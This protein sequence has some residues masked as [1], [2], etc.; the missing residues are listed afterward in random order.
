ME[1]K[2][3]IDIEILRGLNVLIVEDEV[4]VCD[5]LAKRI[6]KFFNNV[7][8][9]YDGIEGLEIFRAEKI[10]LIMTDLNM[11]KMDGLKMIEH[12]REEDGDV[13]IILITAQNDSANLIAAINLNI[14]QFIEKPVKLRKLYDSMGSA[15]QNEVI[16]NLQK[17]TREQ[18]IE[19]MKHREKYTAE[20]MNRAFLKELSLLKNDL[21]TKMWASKSDNDTFY[22]FTTYYIP[23]EVL[24]GD[25]FSLRKITDYKHF[26]F[27]IDTMGKGVSA[28]V[29]TMLSVAFINHACDMALNNDDFNFFD[30]VDK[31]IK[32][33][34][35]VLLDDE[36]VSAAFFKV[37][38]EN[39][40]LKYSCFGM[41]AMLVHNDQGDIDK[42]KSNN[43]PISKYTKEFELDNIH[44]T[45][46]EKILIYSDGLIE[47]ETNEGQMYFD[48]IEED[49]R[50]SSFSR[51]FIKKV[52]E[53]IK[54]F[55]DDV[56]IIG[57]KKI[58]YKPDLEFSFEI[59]TRR[60]IVEQNIENFSNE[61]KSKISDEHIVARA[62]TVYHEMLMNAY[63]HGNLNLSYESK[64][65]LIEMD[66][67][68][69]H[70]IEAEKN[71]TKKIK[72]NY[73]LYT[74]SGAKFLAVKVEDEGTGFNMNITDRALSN[75]SYYNGRGILMSKTFADE[76]YYNENGNIVTF[77]MQV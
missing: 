52:K 18:E 27:I 77:F 73:G 74:Q 59:D 29:T 51:V 26:G 4:Q 65:I 12:I 2:I 10:D 75:L 28:S 35:K 44:M 14:T 56:T 43:P 60:D 76:M 50:D 49:F 16:R 71:C 72:I 31:Y 22:G 70:L 8:K 19:L 17:Q 25:C 13:P 61:L 40:D 58:K 33:I 62:S 3:K 64:N 5:F 54:D 39:L 24:S 38:L 69:N 7:F 57:I 1:S 68:D 53:S 41:P 47:S 46:F 45:G 34:Q 6:D 30:L 48:K 23:R 67:Y 36:M 55:D 42:I 11:P 32:Y 21:G 66:E 37:D 9:A 20:Q 63:E 15:L